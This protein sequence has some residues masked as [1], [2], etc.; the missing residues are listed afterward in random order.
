MVLNVLSR[1]ES[2]RSRNAKNANAINNDL[3]RVLCS[4]DLLTISYTKIK[5][6]SGSINF[7]KDGERLD[8]FP[9]DLINEIIFQLKDN[10]FQFEPVR[11]EPIFKGNDRIRLL[12]VSS[13]RDKV[14]QQSMLFILEAIYEPTFSDYSYGFR[15]GYTCRTVLKKLRYSWAGVKWIIK[16]DIKGCYDNADHHILINIL[17]KKINDE[18]FIGL[19]WKLLRSGTVINGK[20][21]YS[22][23]GTPEGEILSP[24]FVNIYLNNLDNFVQKVITEHNFIKSVRRTLEYDSIQSKICRCITLKEHNRASSTKFS[25]EKPLQSI[26]LKKMKKSTPSKEITDLLYKQV[27]FIRYA[28]D[29][30]IGVSG[31]HSLA[32]NIEKKIEEFLAE[33]LKLTLSQGKTEVICSSKGNIKYL[34]WYLQNVYNPTTNKK[35]GGWKLRTFLPI[36]LIIH[37]LAEQN[38]CTKLGRAQR[39]KGWILYPDNIIIEKYNYILREIRN[40]YAP[41]VSFE[42]CMDRIEFILKYSCAHTLANKHRTRISNQLSILPEI[43]L[44]IKVKTK[45]YIWEF[46]PKARV[47]NEDFT[48]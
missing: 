15:E 38:F 23:S 25:K 45:N 31:P 10:S 1:I 39:K 22:F 35:L 13:L 27:L 12:E 34:G 42:K 16:G 11:T 4:K 26:K 48:V 20:S 32:L 47:T 24:L 14:V 43:R 2:L 19:L 3:V 40:Y 46:N 5:S 33:E 44:D 17:K 30:I 37:K 18:I 8:W 28:D 41:T 9:E 36:K 21:V 6:K 29:W 7:G